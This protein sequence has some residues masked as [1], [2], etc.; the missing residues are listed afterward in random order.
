MEYCL[1]VCVGQIE[2]VCLELVRLPIKGTL[3]QGL[4][5]ISKCCLLPGE[6]TF[7]KPGRYFYEVRTSEY[8]EN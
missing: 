8:I 4:L 3:T 1:L 5:A 2:E 6:V 7:P